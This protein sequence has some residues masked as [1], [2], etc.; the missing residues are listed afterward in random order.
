MITD[1][2]TCFVT[3][4]PMF[5]ICRRTPK[6]L[7]TVQETSLKCQS[8]RGFPCRVARLANE[9]SASSVA[10]EFEESDVSVDVRTPVLLVFSCSR[11][12]CFYSTTRIHT[13][14]RSCSSWHWRR[15]WTETVDLRM[16]DAQMWSRRPTSYLDQP[17][18]VQ[19]SI[20]ERVSDQPLGNL[21]NVSE[22]RKRGVYVWGQ[23]SIQSR[24]PNDV[25]MQ[26]P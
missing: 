17:Q 15:S 1:G 25:S 22:S 20:R 8:R 26:S 10:A 24:S 7:D 21:H 18:Q 2:R 11:L 3:D 14:T 4:C 16:V 19:L 23:R 6:Q 9:R 13:E 12:L 5:R